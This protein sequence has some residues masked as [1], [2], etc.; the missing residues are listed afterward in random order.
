MSC[1]DTAHVHNFLKAK[2]DRSD[3]FRSNIE[4]TNRQDPDIGDEREGFDILRM[5]LSAFACFHIINSDYC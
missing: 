4:K 3:S 1:G 5:L 2:Q